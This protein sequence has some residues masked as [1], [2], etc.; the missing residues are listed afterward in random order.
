M[1]INGEFHAAADQCAS[2]DVRQTETNFEMRDLQADTYYSI[3]LRAHNAIG[4]S[5]PAYLMLKTARGESHRSLGT[6]LYKAGYGPSPPN[7]ATNLNLATAALSTAAAVHG[8]V[9]LLLSVY[10]F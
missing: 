4:F 5:T 10:V 9:T 8:I 1:K 3:E 2:I 6:L 7:R